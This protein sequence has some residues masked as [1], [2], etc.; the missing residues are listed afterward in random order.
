MANNSLI[1]A[2]KAKE[3]E[4]YTQRKDIENELC[5]YQDVFKD[6]VVYCNCDDP[7]SS[8]FWQ[9]FVRN[10]K[11]FGLK[12]LMATHYEP[13]EKNYAYKLEITEDTNGNGRIDLNDEPTITQI[14]SNGD[15]RSAECIELLKEAD[16]VVTNPPFSLFREYI[17]QLIEYKKQFISL[18]NQNNVTYKEIYPYFQNNEMWLGYCSGD[19]AFKVPDYYKPRATRY[20]QDETGQKWRSFGNMCWFTNIDRPKRHEHLDL[21]GTYY[22][23]EE[24]PHYDNYDAIEVNQ[25]QRIPCDYEGVMGVSFTLMQYYS[26]DQ[27]E[28]LGM[29]TTTDCGMQITK[30]YVNV[31]QHSK[32]GTECNGSKVNTRSTILLKEKPTDKTYYTAEGVDGYLVSQFPRVLVRNKCPEPRRY[33]NEN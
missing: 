5:H 7:T 26:P 12:K 4:F 21:R 10:F 33:C 2:A 28:L 29:T 19:M 18:G 31:I 13:D 27:F 11:S 3:D 30:K 6:K 1:N 14:Q 24:Y 25:Y 20:W 15:F 16:I 9:Y 32:D 23:P 8:E 22:T 17:A